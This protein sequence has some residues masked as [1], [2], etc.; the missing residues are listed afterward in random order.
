MS[1]L[2]PEITALAHWR[3]NLRQL[4]RRP[5]QF[6]PL[7]ALLAAATCWVAPPAA[8]AQPPSGTV[9]SVVT[10]ITLERGCFGCPTGSILVLRRDGTATYVLTGNARHGTE[11]K[12]ANGKVRPDDFDALARLAVAQG[13]LELKESYEDAQLQDGAWV[14]TSLVRGGQEKRVFRRDEAGPAALKA[15][16]AAIETLRTHI[17]FA[18]ARR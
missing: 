15:V 14:T 16:E 7:G 11:D 9:V 3:L 10:S 8:G 13:F 18:P 2:P 6:A 5:N 12:V 4:L 17:E 1:R